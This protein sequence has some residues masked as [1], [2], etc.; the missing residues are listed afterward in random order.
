MRGATSVESADT[1]ASSVSGLVP[2]AK[3]QKA[4]TISNIT[5][6]AAISQLRR[7]GD[8]FIMVLSLILFYCGV[9]L[10]WWSVLQLRLTSDCGGYVRLGKIAASKIS[11]SA[12]PIITR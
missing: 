8:V 1:K 3:I 9:H 6:T 5:T 12:R 10:F 2:P 11:T 7:T 4:I